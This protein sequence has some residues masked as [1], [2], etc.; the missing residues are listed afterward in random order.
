MSQ[1]LFLGFLGM[2]RGRNIQSTR[3]MGERTLWGGERYVLIAKRMKK[4]ISG[5]TPVVFKRA[6]PWI[7]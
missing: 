4:A 6:K 5:K 1:T 3:D 7:T 2:Y